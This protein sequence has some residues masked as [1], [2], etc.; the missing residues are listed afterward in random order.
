MNLYCWSH[1][2]V[3]PFTPGDVEGIVYALTAQLGE[4]EK[5]EP[6]QDP[7]EYPRLICPKDALYLAGD[8]EA[9]LEHVEQ[10][11]E[12]RRLIIKQ[13]ERATHAPH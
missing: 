5:S 10:G 9:Y 12:S 4:A 13:S 2:T 11:I 7:R 8:S 6:I 3:H 1:N